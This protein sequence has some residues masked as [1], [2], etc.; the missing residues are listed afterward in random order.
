MPQIWWCQFRSLNPQLGVFFGDLFPLQRIVCRGYM[1]L[2]DQPGFG[3]NNGPPKTKYTWKEAWWI[4]CTPILKVFHMLG[5]RENIITAPKQSKPIYLPTYLAIHNYI[6]ILYMHTCLF[7]CFVCLF[8]CL[9]VCVCLFVCLLVCLS[10]YRYIYLYMYI[11]LYTHL[12]VYIA[13]GNLLER[14][15]EV[16]NMFKSTTVIMLSEMNT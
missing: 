5:G 13:L 3:S 14:H 2:I 10:F 7:V 11:Q 4:E 1:T 16:A 8:V 9:C 6:Y 15:L 12:I